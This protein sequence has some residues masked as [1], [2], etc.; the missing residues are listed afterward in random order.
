MVDNV[1]NQPLWRNEDVTVLSK[2]NGSLFV[3]LGL[4]V[5]RQIAHRTK[6]QFHV[7]VGFRLKDIVSLVVSLFVSGQ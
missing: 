2:K 5:G 4:E 6:T 7:G 1:I 3:I